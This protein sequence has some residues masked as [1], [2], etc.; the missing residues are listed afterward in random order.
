M[1]T[2]TATRLTGSWARARPTSARAIYDLARQQ[3]WPVRE[4]RRDVRTLE[5]VFNQLAT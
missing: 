2:P 3:S 5:S 4:L 1:R